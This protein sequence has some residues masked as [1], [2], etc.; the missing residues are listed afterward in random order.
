MSI[1][2]K[3]AENGLESIKIRKNYYKKVYSAILIETT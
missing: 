3:K 1:N 2:W